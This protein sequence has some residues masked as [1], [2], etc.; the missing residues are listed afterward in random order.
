MKKSYKIQKTRENKVF[1][2]VVYTILT[3]FAI[4]CIVPFILL[5]ASSVTEE[6]V[7]IREG[8]SLWP[9]EFSLDSYRYLF[10]NA[11]TL[12]RAYGIT[13]LV[14]VVGTTLNLLM[15]LH[16][17]YVLSRKDMPGHKV[18]S[19]LVVF[20]M[21]FN[22]GLVPTYLVYVDI[23]HIRNT[24]LAQLIPNLLMSYWNVMLAR[25]YFQN[26]IPSAVIEAARVDGAGEYR[27]FWEVVIPMSKPIIA[28]IGLFVAVAYWND[29]YNGMIYI[30]DPELY[31]FQNVLNQMLTNIQFLKTNSEAAAA[32]ASLPSTGVRMAIAAV[33]VI[34]VLIMYP[35]FQ[36]YF[37][38]GIALGAVKE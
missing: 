21:L 24:I 23:F 9:K 15:T 27:V 20:C 31:S 33:A 12:F 4:C 35:F 8:Y 22:G 10:T 19:F 7:I 36:K 18:L 6:A 5:F 3:A 2:V 16:F 26:S 25:S 38:R 29:W 28:T 17:G 30:S 13:I 11:K 34:P 14:T 1:D 37:V 32:A